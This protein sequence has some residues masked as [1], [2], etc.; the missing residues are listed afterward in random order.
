MKI[1]YYVGID[2]SKNKLD[3]HVNNLK[4]TLFHQV[5][6]NNPAAIGEF[7][8]RLTQEYHISLCTI[9]FCMEHTGIYNH[10]LLSVLDEH[11]ANIWLEKASYIKLS[12]G[13]L[14]GKNDKIDA[15]RIA[16]FAYKNREEIKLWKPV[17]E[18]MVKLKHFTALRDRL[19]STKNSL[20][21]PVNELK[22]YE[23]SS[24]SKDVEKLC[25][26]TLKAIERDIAKVEKKIKE[27]I[28]D[29][30]YLSSLF[31]II[32]SVE[33]V[34]KETAINII[35]TTNEFKDIKEAKKYA[36]YAGVV[37]FTNESGKFKGR[38]RVS[39]QANKKSK[40]LLH[41]AALSAIQYNQDMKDYFERKIAD[42]KNKMSVI[43]AIR[44][45]LI[46]RIFACVKQ[47]REYEISYN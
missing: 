24:I 30:D 18:V 34:G 5:V 16:E 32:T 14:R 10:H 38:A 37:P 17:R 3:F 35:I 1:T 13:N 27:L 7:L 25:S 6:T 44:N 20:K 15:K 8:K 43:N 21:V 36:C 2:I 28:D 33:G 39:H 12:L 19:I 45:K 47:N 29:D 4:E 42:G 9:V 23:T 46:A 40:K 22:D 26:T 31:K 41:M 11:K